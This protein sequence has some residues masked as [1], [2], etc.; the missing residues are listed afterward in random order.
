[1]EIQGKLVTDTWFD[2][3]VI[4]LRLN[5]YLLKSAPDCFMILFPARSMSTVLEVNGIRIPFAEQTSRKMWRDRVDTEFAEAT[6]IST[7]NL[8]TNE[9]LPFE[10]HHRGELLVIGNFERLALENPKARKKV[11]TMECT[12]AISAKSS[13]ILSSKAE[14]LSG[15]SAPFLEVYVAGKGL[16]RPIVLIKMVHLLPRRKWIRCIS[17]GA[18]LENDDNDRARNR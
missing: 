15:L 2:V 10:H 16:G 11:W 14:V 1:M 18:I 8:H 9:G 13:Y 17:L 3:R 6:Y 4:Y 5:S 7:N 12:F